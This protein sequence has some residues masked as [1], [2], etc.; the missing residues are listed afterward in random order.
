ARCDE[1]AGNVAEDRAALGVVG[2]E[3]RVATPA[4]QSRG[5]LPAEIDRVLEPV[6]EAEAPIGR[7]TVGGIARDEGAPGAIA[8]GDCDTQVPI[9]EMVE[10]AREGEARGR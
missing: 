7:M 8:L 1:L 5:E 4:L 6:V 9:A 3:Q 2:R 10:F